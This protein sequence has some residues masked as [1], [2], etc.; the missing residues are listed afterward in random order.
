MVQF[1][2]VL[3]SMVEF[4]PV[5]DIMVVF[6][7]HRQYVSGIVDKGEEPCVLRHKS[8]SQLVPLEA[9]DDSFW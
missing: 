9:G 1:S 7:S 6:S 8:P 5:L 4:P 3:D 2:P